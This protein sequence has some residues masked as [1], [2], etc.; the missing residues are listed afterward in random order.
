MHLYD[1]KNRKKKVSMVFWFQILKNGTEKKMLMFPKKHVSKPKKRSCLHSALQLPR[2]PRGRWGVGL[3]APLHLS[4]QPG[5]GREQG[6]GNV[7]K[8][9]RPG[10]GPGS[11]G[12]RQCH[13]QIQPHAARPV[14]KSVYMCQFWANIF[15]VLCICR[16]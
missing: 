8:S 9:I 16:S 12:H 1:D 6:T 2:D 11:A 14:E 4:S 10:P 3:R 5:G 13:P 7:S 15:E